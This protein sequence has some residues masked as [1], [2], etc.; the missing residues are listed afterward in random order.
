VAV[1][2]IALVIFMFLVYAVPNSNVGL[3]SINTVY[4]KLTRM[5]K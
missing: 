3:G 1:I 5:A 2:Y 4:D